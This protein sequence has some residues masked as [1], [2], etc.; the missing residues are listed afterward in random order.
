[1]S[2]PLLTAVKW[3]MVRLPKG[4][5]TDD[6]F[7]VAK[8]SG[9]DGISLTGPGVYPADEVK[10]ARDAHQLPVHNVNVA[11]HWNVR[12]SDP[13][14]AVREA[15]L[16]NTLGAIE[17]AHAVG[18]S[19]VL[20]VVGKATDPQHENAGQVGER[21][22]EQLLKALP[23]ASRLGVRIA[24]EN[25]GNDHGETLGAW[26][27]YLESFR[28]PWI[29]AFFDIGNH[30]R[31]DGGAAAWIRGLGPLVMKI[32]VKD[33]DHAA[34]KNC[35]LFQGNVDWEAVRSALGEIG[36]SGWAT[37]EVRGGG[38]DELT[39]VDRDM[40]KALGM[41]PASAEVPA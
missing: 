30:D 31:F 33:H 2:H 22:R 38:V 18:A 20:Q 21:S 15:S 19:T 9:F 26:K 25:V 3:S 37:A 16:R 24:C 12:L 5:T 8:A 13:D 35:D 39:R 4:A 7:R 36:Y 14:P 29:G 32:D 40:R 41:G 17:F 27:A 10:R 28:S 34:G 11:D 23:V 1:M 6:L